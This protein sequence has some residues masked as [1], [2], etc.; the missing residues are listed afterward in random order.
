MNK[1]ILL[2][3]LGM[4]LISGCDVYDTL[5]VE[6]YTDTCP[7]R[8]CKETDISYET[9]KEIKDLECVENKTIEEQQLIEGV[10][11]WNC[12]DKKELEYETKCN[13][14][15][16]KCFESEEKWNE[17]NFCC[18]DYDC[19][20]IYE[21]SLNRYG[22]IIDNIKWYEKEVDVRNIG[23]WIEEHIEKWN[24]TICTKEI[25]VRRIQ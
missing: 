22:D 4:I 21:E 5:Y 2:L 6:T 16:T 1:L 8:W 9:A 7:P 20:D 10:I 11:D 19:Y 12:V 25:L 15:L 17:N 23:C 24:E 3:I 13:N 18:G 14:L